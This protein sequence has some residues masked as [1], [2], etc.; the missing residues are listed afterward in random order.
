MFRTLLEDELRF[1]K[2]CTPNPTRSYYSPCQVTQEFRVTFIGHSRHLNFHT[3]VFRRTVDKSNNHSSGFLVIHSPTA[4][5]GEKMKRLLALALSVLITTSVFAQTDSQSPKPKSGRKSSSAAPV[6]KQLEDMKDAI[7]AQQ[8]QIMQ[9]QQQ[10]QNRDQAIQTLQQQVGQAQS[11]AQQAQQAAAAAAKGEIPENAEIGGLQ[12]DVTDLKAIS[13]TTVNELQDTQKRVAGLESPPAIHFKGITITPGGFLAAETYYRNRATA[14]EATA[15]N[16]IPLPGASQ[17]N[18]SEFYGS[19]RQ[20][21]WSVL[22][23]GKAG[24]VNG[25]GYYE[26]DF[27]SAGVT[28]NNNQTN[29]YTLRQRQLYAQAALTNGWTF[30]GGQMWTLVTETKKGVDNRTEATPLTIDPNYTVG[31]SF[32]R[33]YAF[34]VSKNINNRFWLAGSIEN[35]QI[36]TPG[37]TNTLANYLLGSAGNGGGLYNTTANYAF[38][39]TPDFVFKGVWEPAFGGHYEVFGLVTVFRD[40]IFPNATAK[41][42][43]AAGAYNA[44]TTSGGIGGNARWLMM[45]KRVEIGAHFFGGNGIGRYGASGLPDLT[46]NANG[47]I[48]KIRNYQALGTLEYHAPKWDLYMYGGDEYEYRRWDFNAQGKPEGYGSPL[49]ANYGCSIETLP[50]ANGFSPGALVNCAGNTRNLIEGTVGFWYKFYN[51]PKGR[52]QMG[53]QF[54][55]IVR[56]TWV[57]YNSASKPVTFSDQPTANDSLWATSFRYYLP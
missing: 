52:V 1:T 28:S 23:Q 39:V 41:V 31:F 35:A 25:T 24:N 42:P 51:R 37:T 4:F 55:Y 48:G 32:A 26:A 9:L 22:A 11:A 43:S 16:S 53:S 56:D 50:G 40:R 10:V 21:R 13:G 27:L 12:H 33:Q 8:Q 3:L 46:L 54:S 47:T 49:F 15:F 19:G 20:S 5:L 29:S 44:N 38:N 57:G 36:N 34:R 2:C 18:I 6:S 7:S 30:T 14:G 17:A 45:S